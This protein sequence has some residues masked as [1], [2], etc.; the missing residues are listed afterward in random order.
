[1]RILAVLTF[2]V[3]LFSNNSFGNITVSFEVNSCN[4]APYPVDLHWVLPDTD[5]FGRLT[6]KAGECNR[7][8]T[9]AQNHNKNIRFYAEAIQSDSF[10]Y[11]RNKS[12]YIETWND[13]KSFNNSK[14]AQWPGFQ[15]RGLFY[16]VDPTTNGQYQI[17]TPDQCDQEKSLRLYSAGLQFDTAGRADWIILDF[18]ICEKLTDLDCYGQASL[19]EFSIW[20]MEMSLA[21]QRLY[22]TD[23]HAYERVG[24]IPTHTGI[25][26]RDT[27]RMFNEGVEV[28]SALKSTPFGTPIQI[29]KGD[30]ILLFNG[31]KV[32]GRDLIMLVVEAGKRFGYHHANDVIFRRDG[33][34]YSTKI[35]LYFDKNIYGSSFQFP[36]GSCRMPVLAAAL[37]ALNE[38][39]FYKQT[40]ITCL[41]NGLTAQKYDSFDQCKFERDQLLAASKQ[42]CP[43]AEYTGALIGGLSFAGRGVIEKV[44]IKNIPGIGGKKLYSRISRA[45]L[46]E[47]AEES[48]RAALTQPPG[49]RTEAILK[50]IVER[51]KLQGA[52]GVGFQVAP[53]I[54]AGALVPIVYNS[55]QNF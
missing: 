55:Y 28:I 39:L 7:I 45:A 1:M 12:W 52:I 34:T 19:S 15:K 3:G 10:N 33:Q 37:S 22:K 31:N 24:L 46:L 51:G 44:A 47:V 36:D 49:L 30:E 8:N 17:N 29:Q 32:F 43:K 20:A 25:E 41:N 27:N 18:A 53:L 23:F 2:L 48:M 50:D 9:S 26:V 6:L 5:Q 35:A 42:F 21:L 54:T 11:L 13:F 4:F 38:F 40:A 16:C 14:T